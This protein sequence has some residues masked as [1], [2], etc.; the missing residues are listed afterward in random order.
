MVFSPP[1]HKT[2]SSPMIQTSVHH[3][4]RTN[5]SAPQQGNELQSSN[6]ARLEA[7]IE[8]EPW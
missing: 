6:E 1:A 5:R 7:G 4:A 3:E 8:H 2:S